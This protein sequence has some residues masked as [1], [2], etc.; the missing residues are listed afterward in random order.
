MPNL[1]QFIISIENLQFISSY[2]NH[3]LNGHNWQQLLTNYLPHLDVFDLFITVLIHRN[4]PVLDMKAV[5]HSFEYF[6]AK[7]DDWYITINQSRFSINRQTQQVELHALRC[8][9]ELRYQYVNLR[10]TVLGTINM[11]STA[12]TN[13]QMQAFYYDTV[14]LQID[15]PLNCTFSNNLPMF[16]PYQNI[17]D[18]VIRI[19]PLK[20]SLW[21]TMTQLIG[22]YDTHV[23]KMKQ[24]EYFDK[25]A[26]LVDLNYITTLEFDPMIDLS[27]LYFI[28]QFL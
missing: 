13:A 21:N 26:H 18:L 2:W 20:T 10:R 1:H 4:S 11:Y 3:L 17:N 22:F 27:Q 6:S 28:E 23:K 12:I 25:L 19:E 9:K 8:S 24:K 14:R 5:V 7:Y 16:T 15:I